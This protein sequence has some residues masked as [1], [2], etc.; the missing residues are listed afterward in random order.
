MCIRAAGRLIQSAIQNDIG[1]VSFIFS[2]LFK[3][4]N[5]DSKIV[6]APF[7]PV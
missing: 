2:T 1:K 3:V 6:S 7:M 5:G 4:I